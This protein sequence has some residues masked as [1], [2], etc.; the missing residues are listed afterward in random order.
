MEIFSAPIQGYTDAPY[1]HFHAQL[2]TPADTYCAPFIH[3]EHGE[4][5]KRDMR[6]IT[7]PLND[8]HNLVPQILFKDFDEFIMLSKAVADSGYKVVDLNLGCPFPPQVKKGRG[9]GL[10][11]NPEC[12]KQIADY[13][14]SDSKMTYSI[15]MRLGV[16]DCKEWREI[17]SIINSMPLSHMTIHPRISVQ[18]YS[19]DLY[20]EEFA[21]AINLLEHP[22]IFNGDIRTPEDIDSVIARYPSLKG[23]MIGRGILARPSIIEEWKN[24]KDLSADDQIERLLSFHSEL[25]SHYESCL[26]GDAQ[27]LS[28]IKPFWEYTED[29]IG[30][31]SAKLI[32]K[33]VSMNSYRS[34]VST[35][36]NI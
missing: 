9:A 7:S 20:M 29:L 3:I 23:V 13:I 34:A 31:K 12:L 6:D 5:R 19:G 8:N 30:R 26:C 4:P 15:K 10:L 22:M 35:V 14:K 28:K 2:Y 17:A 16:T 21:K 11:R 27:V 18:Q 36:G 1:R 32:R 33:A 25:M 24:N